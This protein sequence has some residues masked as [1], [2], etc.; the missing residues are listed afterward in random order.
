MLILR[1]GDQ[2]SIACPDRFLERAGRLWITL[3][4]HVSVIEKGSLSNRKLYG[5]ANGRETLRCSQQ[6]PV[7]RAS[8]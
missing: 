5:H 4:L 8:A 7:E 2:E 3:F 6:Q 1:R